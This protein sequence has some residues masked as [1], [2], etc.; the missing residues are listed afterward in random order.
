MSV[1]I[2]QALDNLFQKHRIVFWY[3]EKQEFAKD[4][5][6]LEF[7]NI[8]KFVIKNNEFYLKHQMLR[9]YKEQKF[10]LYKNEARPKEYLDN[11][12]LDVEFYSG[13]FRTDQVAIWLTELSLGFEF[14][15]V[16]KEHELFFVPTRIE[17]LKKILTRE[18]TPRSLRFKMMSIVCSSDIRIDAVLESLL[19]EDAKKKDDK[20]KLLTRCNLNKFLW[21]NVERHYGYSSEKPSVQDFVM[22]LFKDTYFSNFEDKQTLNGDALVFINRWKDSRKNQTSFEI[23]A[24]TCE[25]MLSIEDDLHNR[26]F[27]ELIEIDFFNMIDK[28]RVPVL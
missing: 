28:I 8:T 26:D 24:H 21:E 27:R 4:F 25:S 7:D 17:K 23:H 22:T 1:Q 12:L 18:D 13:E 2:K 10:L 9:E 20:Y 19:A 11:W 5:E 6:A 16:I 14:G 3:D 15:D